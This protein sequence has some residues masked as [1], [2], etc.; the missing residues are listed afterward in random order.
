MPNLRDK[1]TEVWADG[2]SPKVCADAQSL[3]CVLLCATPWTEARQAPLSVGCAR[4]EYW[5]GCHAL[6]Q[7]IFPTQGSNL[8][9]LCLLHWQVN[10]LPLS[11]REQ[12]SK[13]LYTPVSDKTELVSGSSSLF[14][15]LF[16]L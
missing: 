7:G 4:Q 6:L 10:S 16:L 13:V 1:Q 12:G 11:H 9:L 15:I 2:V 3:S 8:S 14:C 5:R